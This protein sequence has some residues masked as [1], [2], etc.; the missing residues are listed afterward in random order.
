MS[1]AVPARSWPRAAVLF[2]GRKNREALCRSGKVFYLLADPATLALR[3]E[4]DPEEQQRPALTDL[5]LRQELAATLGEREPLYMGV[6]SF[7]LQAGQEPDE[8][9]QDVVDKLAL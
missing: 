7:I 8:L 6:A 2:C 9:A 5:D 4:R 1:A 3:L